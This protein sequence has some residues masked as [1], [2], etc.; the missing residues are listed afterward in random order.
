MGQG[1]P[2][3]IVLLALVLAACTAP[4]RAPLVVGT[5]PWVGSEPLF[6]AR[7][8][9]LLDA[10]I[11]LTEYM[12]SAHQLRAFHNGVI[13]AAA[14]TLEEV[15]NLDYRG[16]QAQVVLVLDSSNGADCLVARP[17][18]KTLLDLKGR[19][20]GS[21]DVMLPTYMLQRALEQVQLR[22]EDV[23]RVYQ[24]PDESEEALRQ[25]RLDAVVAYSPYCQRMVAAGGHVLFD[26]THIPGEIVDVMVVRRSYLEKNPEQA[27]ALLRGWFAALAF[28]RERPTEAARI[29][30][31]RI[32]MGEAQVLEAL[33]GV[34]HPDIREQYLLLAGERPRL[35][36]TVL[37][38]A[39][40]MTRRT[41]LPV[42]PLPE[43]LIDTGPLRR[44][45]R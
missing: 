17:E 16:Q 34:H 9:G 22:A 6:L 33:K 27:D 29:M 32:G 4:P 36:E 24:G 7:E 31:P 2:R 15:V 38:L 21:E 20:V 19:R 5:M 45:A 41:G 44:V 18:V 43:R 39:G 37:R 26:S 23:Q 10:S 40:M 28:M 25:G 1:A 12:N 35:H 30:G 11:H 13:D 8:Q 14:V 3:L 42:S